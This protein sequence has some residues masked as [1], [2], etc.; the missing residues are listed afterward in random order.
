[1]PRT[2]EKRRCWQREWG[3]I[4]L[5]GEWLIAPVHKTLLPL[6]SV[7]TSS[8]TYCF[9]TLFPL[10]SL[11]LPSLSPLSHSPPSLSLPLYLSLSFPLLPLPSSHFDP[12]HFSLP[13]SHHHLTSLS[14]PFLSLS[15][16]LTPFPPLSCLVSNLYFPCLFSQIQGAQL[17]HPDV[18]WALR[19]SACGPCP[20][21]PQMR[22]YYNWPITA[23]CLLLLISSWLQFHIFYLA[24]GTNCH[25]KCEKLMGNL[26]GVN[27]KM[28]SDALNAIQK[29]KKFTLAGVGCLRYK[30]RPIETPIPYLLSE[31]LAAW[32]AAASPLSPLAGEC[33]CYSLGMTQEI[34]IRHQRL[35][36]ICIHYLQRHANVEPA[37]NWQA[38]VQFLW[39]KDCKNFLTLNRMALR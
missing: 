1:M 26:C 27:Q 9:C 21:G 16:S 32:L 25:K 2:A 11:S 19:Q 14:L 24:C 28:F 23:I 31:V 5:T 34:P 6:L 38:A 13:P 30:Q 18:L 20:T 36:A 15:L 29:G 35:W 33:F 8:S 22:K 39:W 7:Y 10:T 17:S 12:C 4:S 37:A 3:L